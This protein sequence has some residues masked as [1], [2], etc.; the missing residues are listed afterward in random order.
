MAGGG[1]WPAPDVGHCIVRREIADALGQAGVAGSASHH[2]DS[3][4]KPDRPGEAWVVGV[5]IWD[6]RL[7]HRHAKTLT[8]EPG[9]KSSGTVPELMTIGEVADRAQHA[10]ELLAGALLCP[11]DHPATDCK[12]MGAEIDRRLDGCD[13]PVG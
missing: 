2:A 9:F 12:T 13:R 8:V 5:M 10:R 6:R 4:E 3:S 11:F 7:P 1:T